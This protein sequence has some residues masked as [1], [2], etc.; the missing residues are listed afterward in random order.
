MGFSK[1]SIFRT[2]SNMTEKRWVLKPDPGPI[3]KELARIFSIS[4]T[5]ARIIATR[6]P[7]PSEEAVDAYLHP[8]MTQLHSPWGMVDMKQAV[9]RLLRAI[10]GKESIVIY[11]DYDADG[12]TAT[13]LLCRVFQVL[14]HAVKYYL[15]DRLAEGYGL[16][17]SFVMQAKNDNVKVVVTVDC[18]ISDFAEVT[19]L[20][21]NGID[22]I[23]T[24]HHEPGSEELPPAYAVINPKRQGSTYPFR[25]LAGVGVAFKL[26]WAL[27]EQVSK[28]AKVTPKLRKTLLEV[29]SYVS[30][31]TITD[32]APLL[33]ENRIFARFGLERLV[34]S[35]Y[36]GL[37]ALLDISGLNNKTLSPRDVSFALGPR[38][39]AAGRMRDARLALELLLSD[40]ELDARESANKINQEN[41]TRQRLC[42]KTYE[43]ARCQVL[44]EINLDKSLAVVVVGEDWHEGIIGI[45]ASR[46]VDEFKRPSVVIA[47]SS[48]NLRGKGS[49]R[50]IPG[51]HL[52]KAMSYSRQRFES[53]GGHEMAA[54]F[55]LMRDQIEP[56]RQEFNNQCRRQIEEGW[57]GPELT[58]DA[59]MRLSN[60]CE[61][62]AAELQLL[63]PFGQGNQSPLFL[64]HHIKVAGNPQIMGADGKHFSF[65]ASQDRTAFRAVVFNRIDW[66]NKISHGAGYWDIVYEIRTND[67]YTPPR[68]ELNIVDMRPS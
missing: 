58:I 65:Y 46:L 41:I 18:G 38:I 60:I 53:F 44:D 26:A 57:L 21:E 22:V 33:E 4:E 56:F 59:E 67:Y 48:D 62:L 17:E 37:S 45:V 52:Y 54:G 9:E 66:L 20:Q 64:S 51:L 23:I 12:V 14:G 61:G 32:V 34:H 10:R 28:S 24:D 11:G 7:E 2:L 43:E 31:G 63:E 19:A 50:S 16:S 68:I 15:P 6:L 49:A 29:L 40:N 27:C 13:A 39:N 55:S 42:R 3:R 5:T 8:S 47:L 35:A 25:D 1:T 30:L 36:P